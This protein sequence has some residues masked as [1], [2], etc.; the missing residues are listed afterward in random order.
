MNERN[1]ACKER[2]GQQRRGVVPALLLCV[3]SVVFAPLRAAGSSAD[4][5]LDGLRLAMLEGTVELAGVMRT[6][7]EKTA[8]QLRA[9]PGS[10]HY[11]FPK[12]DET[13][14]IEADESGARLKV[15]KGREE[16]TAITAEQRSRPIQGSAI[17]PADLVMDF[18][19]WR[20]V[21]TRPEEKV[22]GLPARQ[23]RVRSAD[24]TS[25]YG[26]VDL[27]VDKQS[28]A[29]LQALCYDWEGRLIKRFK[30]TRGQR[31][32]GRWMLGQMRVEQIDPQTKRVV[33]RSY[34][35]FQPLED[36]R[37]P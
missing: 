33:V 3:V 18:L 12:A 8:F 15:K 9:V 19:Y 29:L 32:E 23:I 31:I 14:L 13:F 30:V 34:L 16:P 4:A 17:T 1:H 27:F 22:L 6:D 11:H 7:S 37:Q 5:V 24:R 28:G 36:T 25:A 2:S 10:I 26:V 20:N 21:E 35:D